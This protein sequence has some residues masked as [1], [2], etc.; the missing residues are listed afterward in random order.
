[1]EEEA[2]VFVQLEPFLAK[3]LS[4]SVHRVCDES[5]QD[6]ISSLANKIADAVTE[7]A[8]GIS[9]NFKYIVNCA[10][11]E[12]DTAVSTQGSAHWDSRTDGCVVITANRLN[13][14]ILV[15]VYAVAL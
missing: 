9:E 2:V 12:G 11:S 4:K 1:M 14:Q 5:R 6:D 15:T 8:M 13:F 7:H 10:L 3:E